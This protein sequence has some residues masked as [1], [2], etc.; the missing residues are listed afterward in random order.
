ME[1]RKIPISEIK[2]APYNPRID[3][4]PGDS[5]YEK[6]K[7]S[8]ETFGYVK[9]LVWNKRTGNLVGGHQRL[10]ILLAEGVTEVD[11]SVVELDLDQEKALN[12]ALNKIQGEWN[13][14]KLA[15]L[16]EELDQLPDF[17]VGLTGFDT[18]EISMLFDRYLSHGGEDDFDVKKEAETITDPVTHRGDI[19]ELGTHRIL[20]GD[21]ADL[22]DLKKLLQKEMA[23]LV[24][25]DPP[26]ACSYDDS[27]RP[28]VKK[29][30][31][32][33]E[34]IQSDNM[35]QEEYE[36]WLGTVFKNLTGF[37]AKGCPLYVWNGYR[38][39]GPM[40]S[41]F[42]NLGFH[43]ACVLT[44]VKE[45]FAL[46]YSDYNHQ[47]EF[48]LYGWKEDNGAHNWYGPTNETTVWEVSRDPVT[49]LIHGTQKP[50]VLAQRAIT[51]SSKRGDIVL[52][53]FLG[54]GSTLIAAESLE[55]SCFGVEISPAYCD[56]IVR[57]YIAY[58]GADN[59]SED[60]KKR[61]IKGA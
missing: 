36:V 20:C 54:S 26:Y 29:K 52:D 24:Y 9:P 42:E 53:I 21:S 49:A 18:P 35:G 47:S 60:I 39:F 15:V 12:L 11:V 45:R 58:V 16:M 22:E 4:K 7:R 10:A 34:P 48:C 43:V 2:K 3:L 32:K 28:T 17:E 30:K 61:Y 46:G 57:R 6:L 38:Q 40:H 44:W 25:M 59:V 13:N 31:R 55:R 33:W 56:A 41:M 14:E 1:I 23:D 19:I 37:L 8:I 5:A 50:V 27:Q 51:N